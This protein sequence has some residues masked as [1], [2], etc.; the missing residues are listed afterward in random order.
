MFPEPA[1]VDLTDEQSKMLDDTYFASDPAKYF[2]E[3]IEAV[4]AWDQVGEPN[5][6][7][8]LAKEVRQRLGARAKELS[9]GNSAGS[10]TTVAVEAFMLRHHLAEAVARFVYA[11]IH[12]AKNDSEGD[13]F[14]KG[15][16]DTPTK[17]TDVLNKIETWI[18]EGAATPTYQEMLLPAE[19]V[20]SVKENPEGIKK[21]EVALELQADWIAHACS[22]IGANGVHSTGAYNKI[23]HGFAAIPHDN[24]RINI[25]AEKPSPEGATAEA[26]NTAPSLFRGIPLG[27]ISQLEKKRA[28]E[29]SYL[30]LNASVLLAEC[31]MLTVTYAALFYSAAK[32]YYLKQEGE[33]NASYPK[34]PLGP[35]PAGLVGEKSLVGVRYPITFDKSGSPS[36]RSTAV[37]FMSEVVPIK[38]QGPAVKSRVI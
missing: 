1:G 6:D 9:S 5:W 12:R 7:Q 32:S 35:T 11:L 22:I 21:L 4:L 18:T 13:S 27:F 8:G 30:D 33:V 19:V 14:W 29:F 37:V 25:L 34:L 23:K 15:V 36:T 3:R 26:L 16:S 10:E 24:L 28:Y 20:L 31:E 17:T 38:M 2:R